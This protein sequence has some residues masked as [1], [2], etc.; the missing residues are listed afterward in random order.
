MYILIGIRKRKEFPNTIKS[1]DTKEG[2]VCSYLVENYDNYKFL[3][4]IHVEGNSAYN[5]EKVIY[6]VPRLDGE[7]KFTGEYAR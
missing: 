5:V 2:L 1:S 7:L 4:V 6:V 3:G